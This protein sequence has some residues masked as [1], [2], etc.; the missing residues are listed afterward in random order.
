[1]SAPKAILFDVGGT[2]VEPLSAGPAVDLARAL[3]LDAAGEHTLRTLVERNVFPSP[4][5]LAERVRDELGVVDDPHLAVTAYWHAAA[6]LP[7]PRA[8]ATT[9][10]AAIR[11][12]VNAGQVSLV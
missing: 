12:G 8:D 2:L 4:D 1:M 9:C 10:V 6:V 3:G 5:A 7:V 11:A